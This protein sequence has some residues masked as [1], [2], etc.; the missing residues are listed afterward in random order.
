MIVYKCPLISSTQP[1]ALVGLLGN[2][3]TH[4]F[5]TH[6]KQQMKCSKQLPRRI[7]N[8]IVMVII[9]PAMM[10]ILVAQQLRMHK[11]SA[12]KNARRFCASSLKCDHPKSQL[13]MIFVGIRSCLGYLNSQYIGQ[14]ISCQSCVFSFNN[15]RFPSSGAWSPFGRARLPNLPATH[16]QKQV[17]R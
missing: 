9:I 6:Q 10:I 3:L 13:Q 11:T 5:I 7:E 4:V 2:F 14:I 8:I 12:E 1:I 17:S 15:P 16:F